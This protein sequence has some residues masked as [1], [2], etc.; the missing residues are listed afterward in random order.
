MLSARGLTWLSLSFAL[1]LVWPWTAGCGSTPKGEHLAGAFEFEGRDPGEA[2]APTSEADRAVLSRQV[3]LVDLYGQTVSPL[4]GSRPVAVIFTSTDCAI[5]DGYGPELARLLAGYGG[6]VDFWMV[7]ADRS[8]ILPDIRK[9]AVDQGYRARIARDLSGELARLTGA[10]V[11]PQVALFSAA[12]ELAYTGRIDDRW[13]DGGRDRGAAS[14]HDLERV[15]LALLGG[16][17]VDSIRTAAVGCPLPV[18]E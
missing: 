6:E 2:S 1:A 13:S 16:E 14:V 4:A 5:A 15:L 18:Q 10:R 3:E 12:G 8:E 7:Y 17:E 9:H 11:T